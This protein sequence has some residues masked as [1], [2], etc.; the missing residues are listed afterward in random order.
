MTRFR[1]MMLEELQA[2]IT[3][4]IPHAITS[5]QLKTLLDVPDGRRGLWS[6]MRDQ[7]CRNHASHRFILP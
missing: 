6:R 7:T 3:R 4:N 2:V 5:A 1:K